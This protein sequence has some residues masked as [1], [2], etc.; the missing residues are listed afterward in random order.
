MKFKACKSQN[1]KNQSQREFDTAALTEKR[2]RLCL[3]VIPEMRLTL[4]V[5]FTKRMSHDSNLK[6]AP[7]N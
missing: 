7:I 2:N 5:W 4:N 6:T 3:R 1:F